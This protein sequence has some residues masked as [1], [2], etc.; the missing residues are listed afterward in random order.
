M[1][2]MQY[3]IPIMGV[4]AVG[5]EMSRTKEYFLLGNKNDC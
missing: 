4:V 5:K 3:G 1:R 2:G